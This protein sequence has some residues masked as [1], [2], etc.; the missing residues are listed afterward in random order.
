MRFEVNLSILVMK[1]MS[2]I[3]TIALLQEMGILPRVTNCK[4]CTRQ[5]GP[6]LTNNNIHYFECS[7]CK[8]KTSLLNNTVL[9]N[10]NTKLR[11]FVLLMYQF[12]DN[13]KTYKT[14]R[15]DTH[16]KV[17][18]YK[19]VKLSFAT[20]NKWFSYFRHLCVEDNKKIISKIG[21]E[22]DIIEIDEGSSKKK[23]FFLR[24]N[25]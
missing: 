3:S 25:S 9:S 8:S 24:N 15:K 13:H 18:G 12:C 4:V 16:V 1:M 6:Y 11:E 2:V 14:V 22:G 20:I 19:D 5:L 7:S 21:G 10:S 17:D 23:L